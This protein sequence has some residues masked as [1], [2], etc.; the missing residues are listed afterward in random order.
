MEV[1]PEW[2]EACLEWIAEEHEGNLPREQELNDI[3]YDQWMQADLQEIAPP[4]LPQMKGGAHTM[5]GN[6]AVQVSF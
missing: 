1:R 4:V 3:V 5:K 2:C 6:F